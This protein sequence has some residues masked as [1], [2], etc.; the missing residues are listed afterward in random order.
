MIAAL[1][2]SMAVLG[3][4]D[5]SGQ[6]A[7]THGRAAHGTHRSSRSS[8]AAA[9]ASATEAA[10]DGESPIPNK[11]PKAAASYLVAV[12]G[13][14]LWAGKPDVPRLPASLTKI[15]TALVLLEG[16]WNPDAEV[17]VSRAAASETGS[18]A[19][20]RTG[21]TLR[22]GDLLTAMLVKSAN[23]ACHA[24]AENAAGSVEAFV[25][26][27]NARAEGLGLQETHFENPCGHDGPD[28]R[29]SAH[30]LMIL[31]DMAL[32]HPEFADTVSL[33]EAEIRTARGRRIVLRSG[34]HLLGKSPGVV[35]VKTG[36]TPDAGKCL[37]AL[38]VRGGVRVMLVL[39]HSPNRWW[40]AS[41]ILEQAFDAARTLQSR[42]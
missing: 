8:A 17:V 7:G 9:A 26:T 1:L 28:Q 19:H 37:V 15:M 10:P 16:D 39:L 32:T 36:F 11:F 27:M 6:R 31:A 33:P 13:R 24:L 12:D 18:R 23:D 21:E 38:A 41:T 3:M 35:G 29:S 5:P 20:L 2:L 30:D 14:V 40:M 22:A 42:R 25:A 4:A 34:N